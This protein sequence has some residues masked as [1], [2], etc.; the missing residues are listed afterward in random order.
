MAVIDYETLTKIRMNFVAH[1]N[2]ATRTFS[3]D[4]NKS[5]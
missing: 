1:T 5:D 2:D 3:L 4:N